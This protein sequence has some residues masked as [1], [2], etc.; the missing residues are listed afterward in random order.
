MDYT[1]SVV[2]LVTAAENLRGIHFSSSG[3]LI[4]AKKKFSVWREAPTSIQT[5]FLDGE[6]PWPVQGSVHPVANIQVS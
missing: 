4:K 1:T 3:S 2:S 6:A 5:L